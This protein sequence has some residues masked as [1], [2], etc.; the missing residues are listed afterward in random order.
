MK[1]QKIN[2]DFIEIGT[3]NFDTLIETCKDDTIGLSIEPLKVYLDTLP[4]KTNVSK[5]C[6]AISDEDGEIEIY[7]IPL[8]QIHKYNL[9]IWVKGCNSVSKPHEYAK[10]TLGEEFYD[11]V[12]S[13]DK[14]KMMSWKTLISEYNINTIK[15]L[16]IDTE[17]H[18]HVILKSYITECNKNPKLFAD[19]ILFEYNESSNKVALDELI[20][21]LKNYNTEYLEQDVVL[22]KIRHD[23]AY[24]LYASENY[25][26][27]VYSCVKS[28]RTFSKLPILV[29]LLD[30]D[31][32]VDIENVTTIKWIA[33]S[34]T[35][36]NRYLNST[37]N[38]YIDRTD[39]NIYKLLIQRPMIVKDALE[40]YAKVVAYVDSDSLAT[41]YCDR[42]FDMYDASLNYPYFV[43]GIYDYL[44]INGSGGAETREDMSTT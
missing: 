16:K 18:D 26:D 9:P 29:Y 24:V 33:N 12:V 7:N 4:N 42:I 21:S 30:S 41:Q 23:K 25:F 11:S 37:D 35:D 32:K 10:K 3:S 31:K 17:G 43:E 44:H 20:S 5:V 28:I 39:E 34:F 36:G 40:N 19:K 6:S 8:T 2:Y 13:V 14:V 1:K 38:F 22:T 15:Y 27:I